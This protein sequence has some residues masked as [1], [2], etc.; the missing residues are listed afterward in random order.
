MEMVQSWSPITAR[1][2]V[3]FWCNAGRHRSVAAATLFKLWM[4]QQGAQV[5]TQHLCSWDW[6]Y[7][8]NC[9]GPVICSECADE[10]RDEALKLHLL[11]VLQRATDHPSSSSAPLSP[12][13]VVV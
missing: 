2:C 1:R 13:S 8:G 5:H 7:K 11:A 4:E 3:V 12:P 6:S 10:Q 9:G